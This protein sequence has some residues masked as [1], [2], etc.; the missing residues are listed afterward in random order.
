MVRNTSAS[1]MG[2]VIPQANLPLGRRVVDLAL[3]EGTRGHTSGMYSDEKGRLELAMG[4]EAVSECDT[5][6]VAAEGK[7]IVAVDIRVEMEDK[8]TAEAD[9][10]KSSAAGGISGKVAVAILM[11]SLERR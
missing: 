5:P 2:L 4:I 8:S 11:G 9:T 6:A 3:G 7:W 1:K 10:G